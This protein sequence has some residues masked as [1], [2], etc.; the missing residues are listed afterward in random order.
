MF[1]KPSNKQIIAKASNLLAT[2]SVAAVYVR[3]KSSGML[4]KAR[5]LGFMLWHVR[6]NRSG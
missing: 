4:E 1:V 3:L 6:R 5:I 2:D